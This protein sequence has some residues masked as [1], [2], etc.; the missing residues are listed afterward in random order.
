MQ[1]TSNQPTLTFIE[2][3]KRTF[4]IYRENFWTIIGLVAFVTIP[5]SLLNII[6]SPQPLAALTAPT[7]SDTP[8]M[9][10]LVLSLLS[11]LETILITAPLTYLV[12]EYLF[13]HKLSIGEAFS[14]VSHRFAKIG[15]GVLLVGFVIGL[16][17]VVISFLVVAF[18]PALVF[19]GI[20]L[21]III[22][23]SALMFPV[24]TLENIGP[25]AAISRSWSLGKRR[26]WAAC[27]IGLIAV[28]ISLLL[29]SILG[30]IVTLAITAAAPNMNLNVQFLIISII[31][32]VVSIFVTPISPIAF[33]LIYYNIRATTENL[34][35]LLNTNVTPAQRPINFASPV[36][37][38]QFDRHDWRNIAILSVIGLIVGVVGNSLIQQ[39][40]QQLTPGLR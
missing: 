37:R 25:S 30:S 13:G 31:S 18:P 2:L 16:L 4:A 40:I 6:I 36:S 8:D 1:S 24:L 29:S 17:A 12:S 26:F 27:G 19:S 10:G 11:L 28:L 5:I 34:N 22:A 20:L 33:T 21:H 14:G 32:D 38:F 39:L 23:T 3:L 9:S 7:L 35:E 15:C